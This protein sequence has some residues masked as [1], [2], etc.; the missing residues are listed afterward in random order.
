MARKG[1]EVTSA[2]TPS[3]SRT[4]KNSNRGRDEGFPAERFDSQSHHNRWKTMEHRGITHE[5]I[6]YFSYREPDFM[7]DRIE[8]LG[9][10]FMGEWHVQEDV[11]AR[12]NGGLDLNSVYQVIRRLGNNWANNPA[13]HTIRE[14]KIDNAILNAQATTWHKLIIAN[15]DPK[16]HGTTFDMNHA[17]LIY[18]LMTEGVVNL[19]H[20]MWDVLLK[21][22]T[23]NP[24][25]LLPYP[26]FIARLASRYQLPEFPREEIYNVREQDMYCPYGDWKGEQPKPAEIPSSSVRHTPEHSLQEVMRYLRRQEHLQL[27]TQS[28]LR[29][30]FPDTTFRHL[31]P[32]T[33]SEDDS[34]AES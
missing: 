26:V 28:M 24:R 17:I 10:G 16:Q 19:S 34:N 30:T 18:V 27:N 7:H 22:S 20:I 11:E 25:N 15:I 6:I 9:W 32:V 29:D 2:S 5:W 4:T 1:K 33:S 14:I 21:R 23:G 12:K 8:E 3:R 31:L 13:D